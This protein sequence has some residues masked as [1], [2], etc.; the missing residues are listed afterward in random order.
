VKLINKRPLAT[1]ALLV[2]LE[3]TS[4]AQ[5]Q[6]QQ[7]TGE[8]GGVIRKVPRI[9]RLGGRRAWSLLEARPMCCAS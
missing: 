6:A 8:S 2:V 5:I 9:Q 3:L 4:S 1:A 7:A